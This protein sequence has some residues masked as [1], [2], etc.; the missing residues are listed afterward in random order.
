MSYNP[1]AAGS[2]PGYIRKTNHVFHVSLLAL[3]TP[4]KGETEKK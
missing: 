1:E 4:H 3:A 2:R